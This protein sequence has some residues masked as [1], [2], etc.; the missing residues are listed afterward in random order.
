ME[1]FCFLYVLKMIGGVLERIVL[2]YG[3]FPARY[4]GEEFCLVVE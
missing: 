1:G 4:G 3:A 2:E